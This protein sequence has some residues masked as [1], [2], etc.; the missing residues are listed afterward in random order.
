LEVFDKQS[1]LRYAVILRG[2]ELALV[3]GRYRVVSADRGS[4]LAGVG[5][6]IFVHVLLIGFVLSGLPKFVAIPRIPRETIILL[7][8]KPEEV[9]ARE[10]P[11]P[12]QTAIPPAVRYPYGTRAPTIG[13]AAPNALVIPLLRCAPENLGNLSPEEQAKCGSFG[14]SPP[15]KNTVVELRSHVRDP[16]LH[17]AELAARRAPARADCTRTVTRAI[18]NIAQ[19]NGVMVDTMCALGQIQR[20]L[21]RR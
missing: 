7:M 14:L 6:A 4:R 19:D 20:A 8:P 11:A 5:A 3:H 18:M 10:K 13:P 21:G 17:A 16:A 9:K 12:R 1:E 2:L 15:D